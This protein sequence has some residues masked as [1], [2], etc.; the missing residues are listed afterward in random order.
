MAVESGDDGSGGVGGAGAGSFPPATAPET[1][2][3]PGQQQQQK[4]LRPPQAPALGIPVLICCL[5]VTNLAIGRLRLRGVGVG[6]AAVSPV[7]SGDSSPDD[8]PG[9][10]PGPMMQIDAD[11]GGPDAARGDGGGEKQLGGGCQLPSY[12]VVSMDLLGLEALW[13]IALEVEDEEVSES[14]IKKLCEVCKR[15]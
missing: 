8:H 13:S 5:E 14:A 3:A 1:A 4:R 12:V 7:A 9:P 11:G 6:G 2:G 10:M 15:L